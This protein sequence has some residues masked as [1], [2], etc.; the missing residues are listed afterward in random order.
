MLISQNTNIFRQV[1]NCQ[2]LPG[3]LLYELHEHGN[4]LN[5]DIS[6]R[7]VATRFRYGRT[8][9]YDFVANLPLS[10]PVEEYWKSVNIWRSYVQECSVLFFTD[11][12]CSMHNCFTHDLSVIVSN[13]L[14]FSRHI[15]DIMA[16]AQ[17]RAGLFVSRDNALLMHALLVYVQY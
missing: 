9:K 6:Q 1:L 12:Q 10:L 2:V 11:S 13:D 14:S 4:F 3:S 8:F 7:S 15:N 17:K 5:I 16:K